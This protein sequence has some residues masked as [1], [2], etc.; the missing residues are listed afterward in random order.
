MFNRLPSHEPVSPLADPMPAAQLLLSLDGRISRRTFWRVG[1][2]GALGVGLVLTALL[3][4]AGLSVETTEI[5]TSLGLAWPM[6]AVSAKRWHDR[7]RS[8]HW[9]LINLI[10]TLGPLWALIDNGAVPGDP[11][12]N[13]YGP[14]PPRSL[15]D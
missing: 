10:P 7:G 5:V 4:I 3:R 11:G 14:P 2:F 1:V 8:A 15:L 13:A 6:I 12:P 9:V